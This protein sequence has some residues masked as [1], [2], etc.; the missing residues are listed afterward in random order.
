[1]KPKIALT[2]LF[3]LAGCLFAGSRAQ[4]ENV[5]VVKD[6]E[7][8]LVFDQAVSSKTAKDGDRVAMHVSSNVMTNGKTVIPSGTKVTAIVA[9]VEKRKHFGV[10]AKLRLAFDPI[11]VP[12]GRIDIEP[13]DK[14]KYTGT[15]TDQAGA[16]AGGGALLLGPVGLA[17]GYFVV[18]K[19]V[20][21]KPGDTLMTDVVHDTT[22]KIK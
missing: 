6:T 10:N 3:A 11:R 12:G 19:Q 21:I 20:N 18:G 7:V 8:P 5:T 15:R 13:K 16:A 9:K 4:A 2:A 17:G 1:M 14:G 22:L